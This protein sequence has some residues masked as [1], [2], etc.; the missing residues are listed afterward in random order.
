MVGVEAEG[1]GD[2]A[3]AG[4][5]RAVGLLAIRF[6]AASRRASSSLVMASRIER[7]GMLISMVSPSRTSA[8]A[9]PAAAIR[10]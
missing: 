2:L 4:R 7:S 1:V 5:R 6:S 3:R 9:P 10:D 8:M